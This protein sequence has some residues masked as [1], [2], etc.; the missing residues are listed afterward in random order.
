MKK[1]GKKINWL[2]LKLE[3]FSEIAASMA[4]SPSNTRAGPDE[5]VPVIVHPFKGHRKYPKHQKLNI[6]E[7]ECTRKV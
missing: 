7:R 6:E 5:Q 1:D 4:S 3:G 2:A